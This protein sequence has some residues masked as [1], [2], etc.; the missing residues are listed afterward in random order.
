M[1]QKPIWIGNDHGGYDLKLH[2]IDY[3]KSKGIAYHDVG[4]DSAQIVRYPY[5]A[6]KVAEAVSGGEADR[7][8]LIC[9]TG[10]G[11][12]IFANRFKGIRA[13]L[14]TSTY[15]GRMTRAHNNSNLLCLGGKITGV[16]EALDI[17]ETWLTT[18]YEGGR[19]DISLGLIAEAEEALCTSNAWEHGPEK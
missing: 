5:Y 13:S 1:Q 2:I 17:L 8:I 3:F 18:E 9:S 10:I 19:H 6:A 14:C 16:L 11:M 4:T 15:M 7:G 12:S